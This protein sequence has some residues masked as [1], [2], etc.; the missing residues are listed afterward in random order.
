MEQP[1][2]RI[3]FRTILLVVVVIAL[4]CVK[5]LVLHG[6]PVVTLAAADPISGPISQALSGNHTL[7]VYGTDFA[8]KNTHY[9]NDSPPWVVTSIVGLNHKLT[10]GFVV[11]KQDTAGNYQV[12]L[13]PGSAFD[14]SY[15]QTMPADVTQYLNAIGALYDTGGQ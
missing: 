7:P 6:V 8:L 12:V 14:R 1:I 10:N 9:F 3:A 5:P 13:G 4:F 15:T 2:K 11:L